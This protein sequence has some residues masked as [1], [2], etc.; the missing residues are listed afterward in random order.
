M[1]KVFGAL[2]ED[3]SEGEF[4]ISKWEVKL[5][6]LRTNEFKRLSFIYSMKE[7]LSESLKVPED[8]IYISEIKQDKILISYP[9]SCSSATITGQKRIFDHFEFSDEDFDTQGDR[10]YLEH[11]SNITSRGGYPYYQPAGWRRYGIN[12]DSYSQKDGSDHW[13]TRNSIN[14]WAVMYHGVKNPTVKTSLGIS[15][16]TAIAKYGL[17]VGTTHVH[18]KV[19]PF[20][21]K[22]LLTILKNKGMSL[23]EYL[24]EQIYSVTD[25]QDISYEAKSYDNQLGE[26]VYG[27][28]LLQ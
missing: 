6:E 24:S 13:I 19:P 23:D 28:P 4:E 3:Y 5:E 8:K 12:V 21:N 9:S 27:S 17:K 18:E 2:G 10:D 1:L 7:I 11:P 14:E 26:G 15:T 22:S 16:A 25:I 20:L